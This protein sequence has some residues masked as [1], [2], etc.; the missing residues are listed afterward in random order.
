LR[1]FLADKHSDVIIGLSLRLST[2]EDR[3]V[4]RTPDVSSLALYKLSKFSRLNREAGQLGRAMI[5]DEQER[6][7]RTERYWATACTVQVCQAAF[8]SKPERISN[9]VIV[10]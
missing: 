2:Q 6:V 3:D 9:W 4:Y 10:P 5:L 1:Q 7:G 8:Y